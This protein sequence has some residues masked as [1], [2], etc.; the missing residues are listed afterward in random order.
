MSSLWN[1]LRRGRC[2]DQL[3]NVAEVYPLQKFAGGADIRDFSDVELIAMIMGTGTADS[4]VFELSSRLYYSYKGLYGLYGTGRQELLRQKGMGPVKTARLFAALEIGR[5]IFPEVE[6]GR[7]I[8]S[9]EDVWKESQLVTSGMGR[10]VF[11]LFVLNT[12]NEVICKKLIS[13]GTV[14]ETIVHPRE[15]FSVAVRENA[16]G[17]IVVHN[18]PSG[19]LDPSRQDIDI[20][21]RITQAG[22]ILGIRLI[23]HLI[24]SESG[25]LSLKEAGYIE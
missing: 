19:L 15:I 10:E 22:A 6:R 2:M 13:I 11:L 16:S 7:A 18:H 17:I 4:N 1:F 21:K 8:G 24:V 14:S 3:L 12:R 5:R 20:T 9:P 23:D 25:Y